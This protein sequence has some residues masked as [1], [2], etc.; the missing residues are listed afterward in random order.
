MILAGTIGNNPF[1]MAG[2]V[3]RVSKCSKYFQLFE[4]TE[5]KKVELAG[6]YMNGKAEKWFNNWISYYPDIT[7]Q[8]FGEEVIKRFREVEMVEQLNNLKQIATVT[9]CQEQFEAV[10][11]KMEKEHPE[12]KESFYI[13]SFTAG[14]KLELD[15]Q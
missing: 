6:L 11:L 7:W 8:K 5:D 1:S 10:K 13:Q 3:E 2:R 12:L 15:L 14:L 9:D 4:A